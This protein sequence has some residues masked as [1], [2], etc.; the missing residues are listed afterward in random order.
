MGELLE[1]I[2][3]SNLVHGDGIAD[4]FKN[5]SLFFYEQ[6]SKSSKEVMNI[7]KGKIQMGAFYFLHYLDDSNWMQYSPIF[8]IDAKKFSNLIILN[9][10]NF[11]FIPLEVRSTIF[12]KFMTE[13]NFEKD[14]PLVVN[15]DGVYRELLKYGFEY[16]IVEYNFAQIQ[17][18]HKISMNLVP[19]F[20]YSQHPINKYDPNKLYSIWSAKIDDKAERHRE[21]SSALIK[22]FYTASDDILDNYTLLKNHIARIQKSIDKYGG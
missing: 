17:Y 4:N 9:A 22:D 2:K 5:N 8:T 3:L 21:M 7:P 11:N 12:D 10:I 13:D 19:R 18:V 20:L 16:A 14:I 6:Y 1:R 15:Y